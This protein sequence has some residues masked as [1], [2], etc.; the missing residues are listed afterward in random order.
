MHI[1]EQYSLACGVKIKKPFIFE[2]FFPLP[3]SKYIVFHLENF[4]IINCF[5]PQ[6]F[7]HLENLL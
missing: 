3:F 4:N 1:L 6:K 7:S 5:Y 2:K